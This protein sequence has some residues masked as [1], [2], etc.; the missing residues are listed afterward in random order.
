MPTSAAEALRALAPT[1]IYQLPSNGGRALGQ[2][3]ELVRR[4]K[5]FS[6][7]IGEDMSAPPLIA[8]LLQD[9]A[10]VHD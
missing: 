8:Q 1:T 7:A 9:A 10:R 3:A 4:V 6:L 2:L 5:A